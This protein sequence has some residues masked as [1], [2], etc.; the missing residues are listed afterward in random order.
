VRL[1]HWLLGIAWLVL[2][3]DASRGLADACDTRRLSALVQATLPEYNVLDVRSERGVVTIRLMHREAVG[4]LAVGLF[5]SGSKL[6]TEVMSAQLD[7]AERNRASAVVGSWYDNQA[8]REVLAQCNAG[9][10]EL[11][12]ETRALL[13]QSVEAALIGHERLVNRDALRSVTLLQSGVVV[14][15]LILS[16]VLVWAPWLTNAPTAAVA[17]RAPPSDGLLLVALSVLALAIAGAIGWRLRPEDDEIVTLGTRHGVFA[18][19]L[20]W[21]DG[22]EP[23]NPPGGPVVFALWLRIA[24]GFRWARMLSIALIPL[25]AWLAYRAGSAALGRCVGLCFAALVVLSPAYLSLAA[26]ARG[27]SLVVCVLCWQLSALA[28]TYRG[29]ARGRSLGAACVAGLMVSYLLWPLALAAPWIAALE[30]RVRLRVSAALGLLAAALAP[31]VANGFFNAQTK[32]DLTLF[33]LRGPLDAIR[34]ALTFA[35]LGAF[36]VEV[37]T[38]QWL[39]PAVVIA[40]LL[41]LYGAVR[42]VRSAPRA[43]AIALLVFTLLFAPVLA[44]LAGGHGIRMRHAVCLQVGL[45]WFA[46]AGL[47]LL[48]SGPGLIRRGTGWLLIGALMVIGVR[49]NGALLRAS[50]GWIDNLDEIARQA[51]LLLIVPR[52][53]QFP[54]FAMLTGDGPEGTATVRWPPV[55]PSGTESACR[56][57][58]QLSIVAVD[59]PSDSVVAAAAAAQHSVWIF[60]TPDSDALRSA[61]ERLRICRSILQDRYWVMLECAGSD[62]SA[63]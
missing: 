53:A 7:E 58:S 35:G 28:R 54:I 25:T 26:I 30:R 1:R 48:L 22:G 5:A 45:T 43:L 13:R 59:Q 51:D 15:A 39:M 20:S 62:L 33:E 16:L 60:R 40:G 63:G 14:G 42:L 49:E 2:A 17:H 4:T 44:L 34:S 47:G 8:V 41:S 11:N 3:A 55:C 9:S 27:Y 61:Q 57:V 21:A 36:S 37:G 10:D 23:F 29:A 52:A 24:G 46:A 50:H 12:D 38:D 18:Y 19:M 6:A 31:R 32:T 56:Q